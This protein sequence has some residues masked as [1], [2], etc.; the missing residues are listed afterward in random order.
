MCLIFL[1][2]NDHPKYKLIIAANR[3]EFYARKTAAADYWKDHP[4][5]VGGRDLEAMGTWM[6]MT[7]AGKIGM[8]T[9][10]R[11]LKNINPDAPTRGLLVSDFLVN[12]YHPEDYLKDLHLKADRYNGFNLLI[13]TID[14]IYY[15]SNYQSKIVK[16]EPGTYGLSN[17]LLDTPWPKVKRGK[18]KFTS[19]INQD[20]IEISSL[21]EILRD[22][23]M[24][25]DDQLPNTGLELERER[26]LSAMFIKTPNY[27]SRCS[28]VLLVDHNNQVTYSERVY[29]L[30]TFEFSQKGFNWSM[31]S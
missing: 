17:A 29:D 31:V 1:S 9:N 22:E 2:I 12:G 3:D 21:F 8:V 7:K 23:R 28:T 30:N 25:P 15:Y 16:L 13:G 6:A 10:Y 19:A 20:E 24:A 18:E 27:G 14:Q 4:E 11:D 5:I 26:A